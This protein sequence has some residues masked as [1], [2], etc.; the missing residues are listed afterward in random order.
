MKKHF[1][2]LALAGLLGLNSCSD[3]FEPSVDF[4]DKTYIN[5]YSALV[6]AVND[7]NKSL[8]ERLSA[9]N[10]LIED[11]LVSVTASIDANTGAIT[12]Q[13]T[14]LKEGLGTLNTTVLNG[15]TAVNSSLGNINGSLDS[16]N[17]SV[18]SV[19]TA[20]DTMNKALGLKLDATNAQLHNIVLS[21]DKNTTAISKMDENLGTS[22]AALKKE[23][24]TQGGKLV[25]SIDKE[26]NLIV[27]A[28]K[29][30]GDVLKLINTGIT[31]VGTKL[32]DINA[33]LTSMNT[34]LTT[35]N[36]NIVALNT[37]L[38]TLNTNIQTL[39][40]KIENGDAAIVAAINDLKRYSDGIIFDK[41]QDTDKDGIYDAVYVTPAAWG[42]MDDAAKKAL[43]QSLKTL[44]ANPSGVQAI[45]PGD[46]TPFNTSDLPINHA[47]LLNYPDH[48][49]AST[50]SGHISWTKTGDSGQEVVISSTIIKDGI[51]LFE[52]VKVLTYS[53]F[54][55]KITDSCSYTVAYYVHV[56]DARGTTWPLDYN[57]DG[58][59]VTGRGAITNVR[60]YL[61]DEKTGVFCKN[62][63]GRTY[64]I[65][66]ATGTQETSYNV[67]DSFYN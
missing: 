41:T 42:A 10:K 54:T 48:S 18:A 63:S 46:N 28:I 17:V 57:R 47:T 5:D 6:D 27:A 11:G 3:S 64:S 38:G 8:D 65:S 14:A 12:T 23:I 13:T 21:L 33:S 43:G 37:S 62:P 31:T 32:N 7:L 58:K 16:L 50:N 30:N 34:T 36:G 55:T 20:I 51:T 19:K 45:G 26:G 53:V 2:V 61:Y 56:K 35:I 60:L 29:A 59:C 24:E 15:F 22:L 4:G 67:D 40:T 66:T 25:A 52:V 39:A 1:Y 49:N 9:L 44:E